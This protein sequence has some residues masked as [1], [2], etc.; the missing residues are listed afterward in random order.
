M[1]TSGMTLRLE[2]TAARVNVKALA[3]RMGLTRATVHKYEGQA[4]VRADVAGD[5]R[6]ALASI[7]DERREAA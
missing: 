1:T 6:R 4:E 7:V 3:L 5:Y 2:R